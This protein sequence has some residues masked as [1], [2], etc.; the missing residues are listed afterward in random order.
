MFNCLFK[1][2]VKRTP[3]VAHNQDQLELGKLI[4]A[5]LHN[6]CEPDYQVTEKIHDENVILHFKIVREF[7][8]LPVKNKGGDHIL[9]PMNPLPEKHW[10]FYATVQKVD[11]ND[12]WFETG[13][14]DSIAEVLEELRTSV[15]MDDDRILSKKEKAELDLADVQKRKEQALFTRLFHKVE[16]DLLDM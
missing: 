13:K 7:R 1:V 8:A 16:C 12:N 11:S 4:E 9:N 2:W 10:W 15:K 14:C 6:T 5:K 3:V